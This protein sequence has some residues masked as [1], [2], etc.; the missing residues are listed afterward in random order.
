[1]WDFADTRKILLPMQ[2]S[3]WI[4]CLIQL[5]GVGACMIEFFLIPFKGAV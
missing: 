5:W 2:C 4:H 3:F 1:M